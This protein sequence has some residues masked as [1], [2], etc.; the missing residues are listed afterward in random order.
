MNFRF[1]PMPLPLPKSNPFKTYL[2]FRNN[3]IILCKN[4][5]SR[6]LV[7]KIFVRIILDSI[8]AFRYLLMGNGKDSLAIW[9][10]HYDFYRSL[11]KTLKKRKALKSKDLKPVS[12]IYKRSI[13]KK[14]FIQ[15]K[16]YFSRDLN[17]DDGISVP[18]NH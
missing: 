13:V 2:N 7:W 12:C 17:H 16:Y 6:T 14:Y 3:L 15:R 8:A 1:L 9:K 18:K 4:H 10:G 5:P 11:P